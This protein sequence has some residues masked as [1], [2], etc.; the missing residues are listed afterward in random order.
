MS[1]IVEKL[2]RARQLGF[3]QTKVILDQKIRQT[4]HI[5]PKI[6]PAVNVELTNRCNLNCT[7]CDRESMSREQGLIEMSLFQKIIDNAAEIKVPEVRLNRYGEPL[8]HPSLVEMI[9]YAKAKGIPNV[10]F[11]SNAVLLT[12]E[13]AREIIDSGL[14]AI[15]F[16][17]DGANKETYQ[18]VRGIP[19]Y[20]KIAGNV[21][22][23]AEIKAALG[24]STPR[25]V[26]N[27][28]LMKE[29]EPEILS[30]FEQW[31]GIVDNIQVIPAA[32]Y[33]NIKVLSSEKRNESP[34]RPRPCHHLFD[35]LMVFWDGRVTVCCGD[36][37]G[38]LQIGRFPE[39][40]L[41]EL[42]KNE[43]VTR[44]RRLHRARKIDELPICLTCDG[45]KEDVFRRMQQQ[46]NEVY[47]RA[48]ERGY[49]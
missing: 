33:G 25:I 3:S 13:K 10:N 21:R 36:I 18:K 9:R 11:T 7:M 37:N 45:V 49:K 12:E 15:S 40:R 34:I 23:F 32:S 14:D 5:L 30:V 35:R 42:W 20:E 39:E 2:I 16:S 31:K 38:E 29:T 4:F 24:S 17:M 26:L 6:P 1:S 48:A 46:R 22:R 41:E 8:L 28:I 47:R 44:L 19:D 27:T 43:A